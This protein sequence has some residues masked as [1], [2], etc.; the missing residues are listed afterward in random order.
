[1]IQE[2]YHIATQQDSVVKKSGIDMH[3]YV[4]F[5]DNPIKKSESEM[6]GKAPSGLDFCL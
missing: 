4:K 6:S 2:A 3:D 5:L 1:M